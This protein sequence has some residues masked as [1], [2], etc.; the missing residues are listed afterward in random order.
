MASLINP[1]LDVATYTTLAL[2][3]GT[4]GVS[5][6]ALLDQAN[7]SSFGHPEMTKV[8]I[9]VRNRP[10]ILI[11][12]HDLHDI[13]QLLEQTKDTGIDIYTHSEMLP[14][15]YYPELKKVLSLSW[16]LWECLAWTNK[17]IR[18]F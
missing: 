15:H 18:N 7:T 10:G 6:M 12:G 1:Q 5:A 3:L 9:G 11:T 2:E 13:K 8:N 16:E 4:V 14:A 17:R